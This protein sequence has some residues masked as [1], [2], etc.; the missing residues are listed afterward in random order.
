MKEEK[1]LNVQAENAVE[2]AFIDF[3]PLE[4]MY[5]LIEKAKYIIAAGLVGALVM[6]FY[7]FFIATPTYEATSKLYVMTNQDSVIN[8]ADF[9][10]GS[11]LTSDYIEVFDAWEVQEMVIRNLGLDYSYSELRHMFELENPANTRMLYI[12]V[13]STDPQEAADIANELSRVARQYVSEV[14]RTDEP[15]DMSQ[16]LVPTRPVGPKKMFNIALGFI[17]GFLI[18]CAVIAYRF[19][20]D[21]RIRNADDIS[22]YADI[23]TL[24]VVPT[25]GAK[26][27]TGRKGATTDAAKKGGRK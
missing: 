24:A 7:S 4:L 5:R 21:D 19:M 17:V 18:T 25:N 6:A 15:S 8:P 23:P 10:I 27:N 16:A 11:Y 3:E 26:R 20:L 14:M 22:K 12:T 9:Q 1:L 13:T 2:T